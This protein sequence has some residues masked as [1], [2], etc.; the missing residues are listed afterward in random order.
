MRPEDVWDFI[1]PTCSFGAQTRFD[2]FNDGAIDAFNLT[3]A[4]G[5]SNESED[6]LD[7]ELSQ[8]FWS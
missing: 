7:V 3:I 5:M 8:P 2:A 4:L 6:L 1:D